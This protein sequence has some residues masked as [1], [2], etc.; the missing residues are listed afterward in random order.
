[1]TNDVTQVQ[2]F[3]M[4]I[5]R[6]FVKAPLLG[7]GS[8]IMA[9]W[10]DRGMAAILLATV[11]VVA[12]LLYVNIR[13]GTP[14]FSRVQKALDKVN[15]ILREFL[16]GVRVVKA[17]N[18]SDYEE[19]RFFGANRE[20]TRTTTAS[21][22]LL[23]VFLPFIGLVVNMGIVLLL[24]FG[25]NRILQQD[26]Q[27]GKLIA[28]VN[29]M[30][31]IL[32]SLVMI[33]NIIAVLARTKTSAARIA[34]VLEV[35]PA[36]TGKGTLPE[37]K[38]PDL[39]KIVFE[40]VSFSYDGALEEPVLQDVSFACREGEILGIIGPTGSGKSSL[41]QL[42]VRLYEVSQG[43]IRLDGKD[44]RAMEETAL[45]RKVALVP[46]KS[47]LFTGTI[48]ENILWG[49]E[50]AGEEEMVEAARKA[51]AHEFILQY[52]DGYDTLVG[53]GGVNLS[54]GQKQRVCIARALVGKPEVLILDDS[55][56]AVDGGTEGRVLEGLL[57][58][59]RGTT[60]LWVA[61]NIRTMDR[62]HRILVME[63][64]K[65]AGMGD[66]EMLMACCPVYRELA[67]SQMGRR[68]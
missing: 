4:G 46:Q 41:V 22:R 33:S 1:M 57:E 3:V 51:Q 24:W 42:L 25:G 23:S 65:V 13:L 61:Q 54:G 14:Y 34:E 48:R 6:I 66:R 39:G 16:A 45:R 58:D 59:G 63:D 5:M 44:I 31:Q 36:P 40:G 8:V 18:R 52:K 7:I 2:N 53:Q 37:E 67:R 9:V 68:L 35:E 32:I 49:A 55:T 29:Y 43:S 64:G 27:P 20:L 47:L 50:G 26:F 60:I 15:V 17:F 30:V 21:M 12:L 38:L 28:L 62:A 10:L 11:P 56:S 19:E